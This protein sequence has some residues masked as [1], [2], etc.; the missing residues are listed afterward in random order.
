GNMDSEYRYYDGVTRQTSTAGTIF[1]DQ[2][3]ER[4][5][6]N[7]SKTAMANLKYSFGNHSISFNSMYI[8]DQGQSYGQNYGLNISDDDGDIR[9]W[10]R[11]HVVDNHLFVNQL[12]S[13][14]EL[15]NDW[16][17]DLGVRSEERRVGKECGSGGVRDE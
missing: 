16:T 13:K 8:G 12:L 10:R 14:L 4:S 5:E 1:L 17:L 2:E 9:L 7:V 3:M 6:Y 15:T 11:Q